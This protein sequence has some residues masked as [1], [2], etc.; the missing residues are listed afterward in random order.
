MKRKIQQLKL[1][2][3]DDEALESVVKAVCALSTLILASVFI[4]LVLR[5][6]QSVHI[7]WE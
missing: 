1:R 6:C 4:L 3:N 5:S 7:I 2:M